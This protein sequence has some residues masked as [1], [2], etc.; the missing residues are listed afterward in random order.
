MSDTI[1]WRVPG[2]QALADAGDG[3]YREQR[4]RLSE[5]FTKHNQCANSLW[6]EGSDGYRVVGNKHNENGEGLLTALDR[7]NQATHGGCDKAMTA[8]KQNQAIWGA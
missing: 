5:F 1:T 4:Q 7:Y 6:P 3:Q 2:M 8:I